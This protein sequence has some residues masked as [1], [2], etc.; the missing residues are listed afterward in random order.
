MSSKNVAHR[1]IATKLE[2]RLLSRSAYYTVI[3]LFVLQNLLQFWWGAV[4]EAHHQHDDYRKYT[5]PI[6]RG[7]GYMINFNMVLLILFGSRFLVT[8]LRKT[9]LN[10]MFPFDKAMPQFHMII[11]YVLYVSAAVHGVFH[12]IPGIIANHWERGFGGWTFCVVTGTVIFAIFSVMLFTAREKTRNKNFELFYYIHIG[13]AFL[14]I[15]LLFLH[16]NFRRVLYTYKWISAPVFL[17]VVDRI[18]R[19]LKE[20]RGYVNVSSRSTPNCGGGIFRLSVPKCFDYKAGQYAEIKVPSISKRQWHPF[21][22]ASAPHE[23][24]MVFYIKAKGGWTRKLEELIEN[25][26]G[27]S[28]D[29]SGNISDQ[30]EAFKVHVRGPYGAPAQHTNQ[31]RSIVLISGGVGSTPFCSVTKSVAKY[32][33]ER[34]IQRKTE[35][36]DEGDA[37]SSELTTSSST[38]IGPH[39]SLTKATVADIGQS[40]LEDPSTYSTYRQSFAEP[41]SHVPFQSLG[42]RLG[43]ILNSVTAQ[44]DRK[45]VV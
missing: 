36:D 8:A 34:A 18:V 21:T 42:G 6:A 5:I 32:V 45:S 33:E 19:K 44:T 12:V 43:L 7:A 20:H 40:V 2:S 25:L 26:K 31:Y 23:E 4:E 3:F 24:E 11:G 28:A 9:V 22:I 29:S 14:F 38:T 35:S 30:N 27:D 1:S 39:E 41:H 13:G 17:Y 15:V 10:V 37:Y 16:G